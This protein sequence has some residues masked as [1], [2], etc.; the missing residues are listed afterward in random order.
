MIILIVLSH[1]YPLVGVATAVAH[2]IVMYIYP[3]SYFWGTI[4]IDISKS[5]SLDAVK[6]LNKQTKAIKELNVKYLI[7]PEGERNNS[8]RLLPFKKGPFRIAIQSQSMILPVVVQR[9]TFLDTVAKRFN[10]GKIKKDMS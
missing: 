4:F 3:L 10:S 1:L 5:K 9:Y 6:R 7:F 8:D 2:K